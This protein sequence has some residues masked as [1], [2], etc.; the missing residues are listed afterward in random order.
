M[1]RL[2]DKNGIKSY[3]DIYNK[4]PFRESFDF[5]VGDIFDLFFDDYFADLVMCNNV[6]L[7]LPS[8][9]KAISE[10][11]R[12]TKRFLIIRTLIGNASFRI[13]QIIPPEEYSEEGEPLNFH[14]FNIYS[15]K[16]VLGLIENLGSVKNYKIFEDKDYNP[17]NIGKIN[18][19]EGQSPHDLTEI[20]NGMQVNNY[21]IQP[22]QFLIIEKN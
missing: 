8:L 16:Y 17:S 21:I 6:L 7:H 11:W 5:E 20:V 22:W 1:G 9:K 18:Y 4:N 13:K 10:L 19:K 3:E 12:V 2:V 15:E 14:F